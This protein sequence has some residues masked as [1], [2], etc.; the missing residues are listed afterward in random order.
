MQKKVFTNWTNHYLAQHDPPMRVEDL[1]EDLRDGAKLIALIEHLS[2]ERLVSIKI[3]LYYRNKQRCFY[4][5]R[6]PVRIPLMFNIYH[7]I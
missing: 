5:T 2:G 4:N 1:V 3:I 7:L 6:N